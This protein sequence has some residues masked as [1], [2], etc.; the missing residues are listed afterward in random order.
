MICSTRKAN[1]S[2]KSTEPPNCGAQLAVKYARNSKHKRVLSVIIACTKECDK[3]IWN[4][5]AKEGFTHWWLD[6]NRDKEGYDKIVHSLTFD[7]QEIIHELESRLRRINQPKN[8]K[9]YLDSI[10]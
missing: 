10:S 9:E 5:E 6:G 2:S 4:T 7:E 3:A 8:Y 1:H